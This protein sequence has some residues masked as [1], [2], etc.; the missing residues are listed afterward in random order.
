M[1]ADIF[2]FFHILHG[3]M[4]VAIEGID[5][6]GKETQVSLL[7]EHFKKK[8]IKFSALKTPDYESETGKSIKK[9]LNGELS[10]TPEEAFLLYAK[11]VL[12]MVDKFSKL[13]KKVRIVL[14]DRYITSTIAYQCA[15]GL[16]LKKALEIT[17]IL[18]FPGI[19]KI[20]FVDIK[21]ETGFKRKS[22]EKPKLDIHERD[23]RYL[24]KVRKFYLQ[25]RKKNFLGEW[26]T[27]NGEGKPNEINKEILK[28]IKI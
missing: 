13:E 17:E 23:K 9:Y 6:S 26:V 8:K 14:L 22:A 16:P 15:R 19:D 1:I 24:S 5:G 28:Q 20:I 7:R 11:D 3:H 21:P 27:V 10:L 12:D 2:V 18:G 4:I 25:Q